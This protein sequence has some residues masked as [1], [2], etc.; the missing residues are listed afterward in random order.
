MTRRSENELQIAEI[1][2]FFAKAEID[3]APER[4]EFVARAAD[5]I[6]AAL[7]VLARLTSNLEIFG[8]RD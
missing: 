6:D 8:A 2:L 7:E 5:H 1:E 3:C 4:T